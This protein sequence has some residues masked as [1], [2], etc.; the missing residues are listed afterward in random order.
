MPVA[1]CT[2]NQAAQNETEYVFIY[3]S[4]VVTTSRFSCRIVRRPAEGFQ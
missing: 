4:V 2:V 3:N 1:R